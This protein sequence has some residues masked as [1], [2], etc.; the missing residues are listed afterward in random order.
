MGLGV[1]LVLVA[2]GAILVWGVT[3][4]PSGLDL[5]AIGII[6]IVI[7]I[8]G[9][10]LSMLMWRSWWG[11]GYFTRSTYVEGAGAAPTAHRTTYV[12]EEPPP[13][14]A[15]GPPSPP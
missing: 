10:V 15:G 4:E 13:P 6:L 2:A 1:S 3:E 5:D 14:P 8:V 7:G 11:P 12:E 9:F